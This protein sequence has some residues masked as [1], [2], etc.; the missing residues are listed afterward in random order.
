MPRRL[1]RRPNRSEHLGRSRAR[2]S[3]RIEPSLTQPLDDASGCATDMSHQI[4][5]LRIIGG[6]DP[7]FGGPSESSVNACIASQSVDVTNT[8]IYP[9]ADGSMTDTAATRHRLVG[10]GVQVRVFPTALRRWRRSRDWG[11]SPNLVV[12]LARHAREYDVVHLHGAW[13]VS[14]LAGLAVS[15]AASRPCVLTPHESLTSFGVDDSG[16]SLRKVLKKSLR[17]LY[18]ANLSLI[19]FSSATESADSVPT[20]SST[21]VA[22]IPHPLAELLDAPP[23]PARELVTGQPATIGFLGRLHAKKN[24]DILIRAVARSSEVSRLEVGGDGPAELRRSLESVAAEVGMTERVH[25]RGFVARADRRAF[26]DSI[27]VLAMPSAYECFGMVAAE[28]L[29][30]GVPTIVSSE[31]GVAELITRRRAGIVAPPTVEGFA[32][33][34]SRLLEQPGALADLGQRGRAAAEAEL[35]MKAHGA[36]QRAEYRLL[37]TGPNLVHSIGQIET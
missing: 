25:W 9:T 16:T 3:S 31:T 4:R 36:A 32:E 37:A 29:A 27:D 23:R 7:R 33:A 10:S 19:V 35:S 20:G 17:R 13:G 12:W 34:I 28:G 30:R 8:F 1:P 5:I 26:L 14:Q 2:Y 6:L 18:V 24:V 11:I 21:A 15:R 22:V